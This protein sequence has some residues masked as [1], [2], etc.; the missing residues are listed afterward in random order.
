MTVC[1]YTFLK[2]EVIVME[3]VPM[4][5][6][7]IKQVMEERNWDVKD[8]NNVEDVVDYAQNHQAAYYILDVNM[9]KDRDKDGITAL[10][11]IM[12]ANPA[13]CVTILTSHPEYKREAK[14]INPN[15]LFLEKTFNLKQDIR[16]LLSEFLE[17]RKRCLIEQTEET[18]N[19]IEQI[20]IDDNVAAYE[21]LKSKKFD[22][23][24]NKYV[25]F[26]DGE[27]IGVADTEEAGQELLDRLM[28]LER[29]CDKPK[30]FTQVKTGKNQEKIELPSGYMF[31]D[32]KGF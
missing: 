20:N 21:E 8:V 9:G 6:Q 31:D 19:L 1:D 12:R 25:A 2:D 30:F 17:Y 14:N 3:D 24:K 13:V 23:Y 15:I 22:E 27:L 11:K 26:V 10:Q 18:R 32:F 28:T 5:R 4:I 16:K 7:T 29:Y